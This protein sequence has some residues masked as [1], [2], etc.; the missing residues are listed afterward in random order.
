MSCVCVCACRF[1]CMCVCECMLRSA[2]LVPGLSRTSS[3]EL[4]L[5]GHIYTQARVPFGVCQKSPISRGQ[6]TFKKAP[7]TDN[8]FVRD[9]SPRPVRDISFVRDNPLHPVRDNPLH[10]VRDNSMAP[11]RVA[12]THR[13]TYLYKSFSAKEPYNLRLFCG[14]TLGT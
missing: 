2:K 9:D 10:P 1:V 12:K 6:L 14:K 11:Y 7:V 8:S 3:G 4:S 5:T 13:M